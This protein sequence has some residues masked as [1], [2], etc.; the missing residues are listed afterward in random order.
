MHTFEIKT[1][2]FYFY[3]N[4]MFRK[5][6]DLFTQQKFCGNNAIMQQRLTTYYVLAIEIE[7]LLKRLLKVCYVPA[8]SANLKRLLFSLFLLRPLTV[9]M[10]Q[11]RQVVYIIKMSIALAQATLVISVQK[12]SFLFVLWQP[13]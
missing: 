12:G 3:L 5:I 8:T 7:S 6:K 4:F 10:K 1:H 11:T 2:Y 9:L 13:R